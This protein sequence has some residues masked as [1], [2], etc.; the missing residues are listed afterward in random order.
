MVWKSN[1][2]RVVVD[3]QKVN[4]K[5]YPDAYPLLKQD[6]VLGAMGGSMIFSSMDI[7]KGFFQQLISLKDKWKTAFVTPHRGH[8]QFTVS[9]MGLANSPGFFQH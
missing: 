3:L 5:L 4:T 9:M 1:K 2:P 7:V 6:Q 8:E